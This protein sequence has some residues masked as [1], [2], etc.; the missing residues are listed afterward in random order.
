MR[1]EIDR[2]IARRIIAKLEEAASL[3]DPTVMAKPLRHNLKGLWSFRVA[4][5]YRVIADVRR[6]ELVIVAID[7]GARGSVYD[8]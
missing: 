2:A 7:V 6:N 4:G 5:G 3:E 1:K 8:D